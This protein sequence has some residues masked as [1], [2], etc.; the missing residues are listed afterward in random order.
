MHNP[1][2]YIS[3]WAKLRPN[4]VAVADET[5]EISYAQLRVFVGQAAH[6]L[7][8]K[9]IR[10][11]DLVVLM[12][13]SVFNYIMTLTLN[14]MGVTVLTRQ[15]SSK[16]PS[17]IDPDFVVSPEKLSWFPE[18]RTL[19]FNDEQVKK[20]SRAKKSDDLGGFKDDSSPS[21]IWSTSG[22]TG[23]EKFMELTP[24]QVHAK[25]IEPTLTDF[26][27]DGNEMSLLPFGAFW[28]TKI[29]L[30]SL[31][32]GDPYLT[33]SFP[34]KRVVEV[35]S[36]YSVRTIL[37]APS[38][39]S[40]LLDDIETS[41]KRT[42]YEINL[43]TFIIGGESPSKILL[44]RLKSR[45]N[46][47][48]FNNYGSS[49]VGGIAHCELIS[50]DEALIKR[51]FVD[52][53]I[54]DE[55]DQVLPFGHIGL[56]RTRSSVMLSK[57]ANDPKT[58]EAHFRNGYHYSGDLGF[59][60]KNGDLIITGRADHVL[61]LG[62]VKISPEVLE[63]EI[64]GR[65]EIKDCMVFAYANRESGVSELAIA[66]VPSDKVGL[67]ALEPRLQLALPNMGTINVFLENEFPKNPNGKL[68]R[69]Q[70]SARLSA[71]KP[72]F[73]VVTKPTS[74]L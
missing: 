66:I 16:L 47:K 1:Y 57:Y 17:A 45:F 63:K 10:S 32:F 37:G 73:R 26:F 31:V 23:T 11:G 49:E 6:V 55:T 21:I 54:V 67:A 43:S 69:E 40:R 74:E 28:S 4:E 33:F 29:A 14:S 71:Q 44:D 42:S 56:I 46:C 2:E 48:V 25:V 18:S 70:L 13:N 64:L 5:F 27:P 52:L 35:I 30:R 72:T 9:G 8:E 12:L 36:R 59:L 58:T 19:I 60:D 39:V 7:Q 22:T 38:Q 20:I 53:E 15:S 41:D 3:F 65:S 50:G 68:L 61:H 34:D 24:A 51:P 62:G